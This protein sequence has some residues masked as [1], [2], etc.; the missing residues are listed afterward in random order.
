[1][2]THTQDFFP[3]IGLPAMEILPKALGYTGRRRFVAFWQD[4]D[5]VRHYDGQNDPAKTAGDGDKH[6]ALYFSHARVNAICMNFSFDPAHW[7][8]LDTQQHLAYAIPREKA[9]VFLDAQVPGPST[10]TLKADADARA[11]YFQ[12]YHHYY[13]LL[14]SELNAPAKKRVT[15]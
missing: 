6:W 2:N 12:H 7:L 1:V 15:R 14:A 4:Q 11:D 9:R 8:L 10:K 5:G 3:I 13:D